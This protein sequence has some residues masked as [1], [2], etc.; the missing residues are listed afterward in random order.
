MAETTEIIKL[1][2]RTQG[3]DAAKKELDA[4]ARNRAF[5]QIAADAAK[6]NASGER[7]RATSI[8]LRGELAKL[9]ASDKEVAKVVR[10]YDRLTT[11]IRKATDEEHRRASAQ[12]RGAFGRGGTLSR[13]GQEVRALPA[14]QIPGLPFSTDVV[15]K[16]TA[17]IGAMG[18]AAVAGSVAVAA[19]TIA[20]GNAAA[21]TAKLNEETQR[22]INIEEEVTR[23]LANA[24]KE[25]ARARQE[26][27]RKQLETELAIL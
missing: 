10:E 18:P 9:G 24:T 2:F 6:A 4:I 27:L 3:A 7:V 15:G 23:F 22:R 1:L 12:Q 14:V 19:L 13:I 26:E 11:S 25:Q 17:T 8:R 21:A 16:L 20:I 5:Q